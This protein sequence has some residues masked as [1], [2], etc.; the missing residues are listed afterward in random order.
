MGTDEQSTP[1]F[2]PL[3]NSSLPNPISLTNS[4]TIELQSVPSALDSEKRL[5]EIFK[6]E[7]FIKEG[8]SELIDP[9]K[10]LD[11]VCSLTNE[12]S[13]LKEYALNTK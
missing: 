7:S 9:R 4:A 12:E 1:A 11:S 6:P 13:R 8:K 2:K 10:V 3:N 5:K